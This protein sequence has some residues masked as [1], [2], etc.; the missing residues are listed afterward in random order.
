MRRFYALVLDDGGLQ[1]DPA[2][3]SALEVEWW[4]VHRH[5][6]R[7]DALSEDDLTAALCA[8]Y[9]YVYSVP[10]GSVREAAEQRMLA[11]RHSDEWH[12]R[13]CDL[14]DPLLRAERDALVASYSA[15]LAAVRR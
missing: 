2:R 11:M 7:E 9:A 1:L 3:A 8:L 13:G 10:A 15:L 5:H 6:Q 12:R 4:R 14:E